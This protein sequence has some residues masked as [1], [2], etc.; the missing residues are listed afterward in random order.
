MKIIE[1]THPLSGFAEATPY[2]SEASLFLDIETTGFDAKKQPIYLIGTAFCREDQLHVVLYFAETPDAEADILHAFLDQLA[3]Y[4]AI[5]TFNGDTF[6]I[7]FLQKRCEKYGIPMEKLANTAT[8]DLLKSV[9][10]HKKLLHLTHCSQKSVEAFL[11]IEREDTYD[12]GQL[13]EVYRRYAKQPN[14]A[15]EALLLR[16]NLDDVCGMALLLPMLAYD[17][18][19][20]SALSIENV[21]WDAEGSLLTVTSSIDPTLPKPV[22]I[23]EAACYLIL[24]E[25]RLKAAL[26]VF[27]GQLR[28]FFPYPAQYVYL[29]REGTVIPKLLASSIPSAEKRPAKQEE[30]FSTVSGTFLAI[31]HA[32]YRRNPVFFGEQRIFQKH[33]GDDLYYIQTDPKALDTRILSGYVKLLLRQYL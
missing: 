4:R 30:C 5:I 24:E 26:P 23:H 11:G 10:R 25:N 13:I 1:E 16:H 33:W 8:L 15:D 29:P 20:D 17:G 14:E 28:Y 18:L 9:R 22:R 21:D 31:D 19:R 32:I 2:F 3:H 12:G 27:Q 6:D 7:P